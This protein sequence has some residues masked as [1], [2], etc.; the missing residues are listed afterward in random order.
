[1]SRFS[2]RLSSEGNIAVSSARLHVFVVSS[3]HQDRDN[4]FARRAR[5]EV[6]PAVCRWKENSLSVA[7]TVILLCQIAG[8]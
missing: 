5:L 1:M 8:P 6:G 3:V 2:T 4:P 7:P